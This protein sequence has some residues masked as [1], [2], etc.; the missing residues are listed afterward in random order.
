MTAIR[1]VR[2]GLVAAALVFLFNLSQRAAELQGNEPVPGLAWS[3]GALSLVFL[4]RAAVTE[5]GR[6][7][8]ANL[9]KDLLW[10][11]GLGGFAAILWP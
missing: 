3:L 10:G 9:M 1:A 6:G 7:P 8:E 5:F 11:L 4:L 2:I